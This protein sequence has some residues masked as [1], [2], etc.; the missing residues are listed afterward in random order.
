[1]FKTANHLPDIDNNG[2]RDS[3]QIQEL[4]KKL[5]EQKETLKE[6]VYLVKES[7]TESYKPKFNHQFKSPNEKDQF[8]FELLE[9]IKTLRKQINNIETGPKTNQVQNPFIIPQYI[10]TIQQP[11][12][13]PLMPPYMYMNHYF[14]MP[15]NLQYQQSQN[16]APKKKVDPYKKLALKILQKGERDNHRRRDS[17]YSDY[18]DDYNRDDSKQNRYHSQRDR[19]KDQ[20]RDQSY[21]NKTS[22]GSLH[23]SYVSKFTR[24]SVKI[25][26]KKPK[27]FKDDEKINLRRKLCGIFWF[28]RI[29]MGLK[30]YLKRVWL[31]R[32]QKYYENEAQLQ[33]DKFDHEFV[34]EQLD[35]DRTIKKFSFCL[36]LNVIR[37]DI[38]LKIEI[39]STIK[40]LNQNLK[41][42]FKFL[43][44]CLRSCHSQLKIPQVMNINNLQRNFHHKEDFYYQHILSLPN[45]TI[46]QVSAEVSKMIQMD[47]IFIQV[48]VQ[49]ILLIHEWYSQYPKIPNHKEAIKILASVLH[50]LFIDQFNNLKVYENSDA[51]YNKQQVVFC[52]FTQ[53]NYVDVVITIDDKHQ[54]YEST[55]NCCILGLSTKEQMQE[56]YDQP[57]YK[58]LQ[59]MFKDYC[60]YFYQQINF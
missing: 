16:Q 35:I 17:N 5:D 7:K 58:E 2:F 44:F 47:Y 49:R 57:G 26:T 25:K 39:S 51:I 38:L 34:I 29:G 21:Q 52:D 22:K 15:Q 37:I 27:L 36:L 59:S 60:D 1:M 18:S 4:R 31:N 3:K 45:V 55:T 23:D 9:E 13:Q 14:H 54:N 50:Q 8:T 41:Q 32:R 33:I 12:I 6:L 30:K 19:Q 11:Q 43:Q 40:I 10:P 28:I 53:I 24:S 48:I 56:L 20:G 42:F 46:G